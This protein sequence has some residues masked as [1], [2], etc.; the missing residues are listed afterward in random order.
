MDYLQ[1][2]EDPVLTRRRHPRSI[3][4]PSI[5]ATILF[6][7]LIVAAWFVFNT[8][9]EPE[10][11]PFWWN[12]AGLLAFLW[13]VNL[14]AL[15]YRMRTS[16][17]VITEERVYRSHGRLRFQLLQTTYDKVTDL[18]VRQG[19][20]GRLWGYGEVTVMTAGT[21]LT[22]EGV[23]DPFGTKQEIEQART[24]FLNRLL[25]E[26]RLEHVAQEDV[27]GPVEEEAPVEGAPRAQPPP[28]SP[29]ERAK[30]EPIW[31]GRPVLVS[32][33]ATA[34]RGVFIL[35]LGIAFL[36]FALAANGDLF[37]WLI[38]GA[39][40]FIGLSTLIGGWVQY[41]FTRYEV[42]DWG[43]VVTSGWLTRRRVE[44]T[45]D[46]VTDVVTYQGFMGRIFNFGNITI[47]TAGSTQAPVTFA[48]LDNPEEVKDMVNE[49]R[50]RRAESRR[51]T[52]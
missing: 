52:G 38:A 18:H 51:R 44:V 16:R 21:G 1:P 4:A 22:L 11:R 5:S 29:H 34:L 31:R 12:V 3:I 28:P 43:V 45:Y 24:A 10:I 40:L 8:F 42:H 49:A 25:E 36:S 19:P 37:M 48:A 47:N 26:Y 23:P 15:F 13:L 20:L 6:G 27:R 14:L 30:V 17:Y 39:A 2:G 32:L 41:Q 33:V 7:G 9:M 46:K 35:I 50:S